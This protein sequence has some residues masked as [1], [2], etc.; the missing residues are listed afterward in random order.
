K[1]QQERARIF[2]VKTLAHDFGPKAVGGAVLGDLFGQVT[3]SIE[4]KRKLRGEFVDGEASVERGLNVSDAVG[5]GEGDFLN[6]GGAGFADVIAGDG[7]GVP[8]GK[9]VAAP[10]KNVRDDAH[11]GAHGIDVSAAGDVFLQDIVLNGAGEF[12]HAGALLLC[13]GHI[14]AEKNRGGGVDGHGGGDFFERD[15]GEERFHVFERID[16]DTDFAEFAKSKRMVGIQ[17][18]LR[19][20][21]EGDRKAS[22]ALAQEVA[23]TLVGFDGGAESGV[24]ARGPEAAA[25]HGGVDTAGV[26]KFAG[27]AEGIFGVPAGKV[28]FGVETLDR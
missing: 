4:E 13:N 9:M 23:V 8:L 5:K 10:G 12:L 25:V 20:E 3:V 7:D 14:Q 26:G 17:A 24:L 19:G 1:A 15:A 16:G 22:L 28:F 18:D 6:G 11:G 21:I 27:I 2:S